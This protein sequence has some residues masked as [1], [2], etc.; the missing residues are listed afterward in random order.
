MRT[1]TTWPQ[2]NL[3]QSIEQPC[4]ALYPVH[5]TAETFNTS[6]A[7][8]LQRDALRGRTVR[9]QAMAGASCLMQPRRHTRG[10]KPHLDD[11]SFYKETPCTQQCLWSY[12]MQSA[13]STHI[14]HPE[15]PI[16]PEKTTSIQGHGHTLSLPT[17]RRSTP[18][19]TYTQQPHGC[20]V[21]F[22]TDH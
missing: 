4:S 14:Q 15:Q 3:A 22:C 8:M 9:K 6:N 11:L 19:P 1:Q 16:V 12:T 10:H 2:M 7:S 18:P 21:S 13:A 20:A 5:S 17:R